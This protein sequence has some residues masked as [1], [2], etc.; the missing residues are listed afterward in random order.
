[1]TQKVL[2][3][4]KRKCKK[5]DYAFVYRLMKTTLFPLIEKFQP[6]DK[7]KFDEKFYKDYGGMVILLR[8]KRR[9]GL[10]EIKEQK[11][12]LYVSRIFLK[13]FYQGRGLGSQIMKNF[14][15]LGYRKITLEVL[16]NNPAMSFYKKLGYV[17]TKKQNH[18]YFL[19]KKLIISV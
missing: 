18:K 13:P 3:I 19:E 14:E 7:K 6:V 16:E 12:N 4:K 8:G 1:M 10:Y 5:D 15:A 17:I 2:N 11:R 9:I